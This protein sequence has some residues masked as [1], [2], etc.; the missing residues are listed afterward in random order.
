MD[1]SDESQS[2][3]Y[4]TEGVGLKAVSMHLDLK[5]GEKFQLTL[6]KTARAYDSSD[7]DFEGTQ[8]RC[9]WRDVDSDS[10][11]EEV[12]MHTRDSLQ[13]LISF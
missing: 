3:S 10:D 6:R 8:E 7:S 4:L 12:A 2:N 1:S 9:L 11:D 5:P 13:F